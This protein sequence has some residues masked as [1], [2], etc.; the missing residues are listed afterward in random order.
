MFGGV[1]HVM[2]DKAEDQA[3]VLSVAEFHCQLNIVLAMAF[4][5]G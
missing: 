3:Q 4:T 1:P 2:I 5:I